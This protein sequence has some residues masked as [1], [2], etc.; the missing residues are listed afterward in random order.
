MKK[1][2]KIIVKRRHLKHNQGGKIMMMSFIKKEITP[3][4][5]G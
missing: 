2:K 4:F 5:N 3:D 1:E